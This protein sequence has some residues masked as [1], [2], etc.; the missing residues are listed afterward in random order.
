MGDLIIKPADEGHLKL[1]NDA[2]TTAIEIK[3]D[4]NAVYISGD[5]VPST[6]LSHRNMFINGGMQVA[7]RG[8][9]HTSVSATGY[10]IDRFETTLQGLGAYTIT[11]N[12]TAPTSEGFTQSYKIDCTSA[13][14]SPSA[15][16]FLFISHKIE[17]QNL[18]HL[19][20]GTSDA[21]S[22]TLSFW[23]R[24]TKTGNIQV[25]LNDW[26]NTRIIGQAV[27]I[28][29]ADTWEKKTLTFA[30]DTSGV[31]GN[32]NGASLV[33]EW[34]LDKGSNFSGGAVPTSWEA[35]SSAD[36][37]AGCTLALGNNTANNFY[38]TGVQLE[39]GSTATP[40]EHRSYGDE[41]A[42]CQRYF[43]ICVEGTD[44]GLGLGV[45]Y[46][47]DQQIYCPY[48]FRTSKRTDGYTLI[49]TGTGSYLRSR[50]NNNIGATVGAYQNREKGMLTF[51][52]DLG[53]DGTVDGGACWIESNASDAFV[54]ID[55]E[56]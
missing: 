22:V 40:F 7:Q 15:T 19:R 13:D 36:R 5:L 8:A 35:L 4:E 50:R 20:K 11:Q 10:Q 44:S 48:Y 24:C 51:R 37:A 26:D 38:I 3:D 32:D 1:Q 16:D 43:E 25:N 54:A 21:K 31:L 45:E 6:P 39:V 49:G 9:S 47:D 55:D 41:L 12:T 29:S 14:A 17:G 34:W 53:Q 46:N 33:L 23:C 56:L 18:Q 30:G 27:T 2:G 28:S 42:K 52:I